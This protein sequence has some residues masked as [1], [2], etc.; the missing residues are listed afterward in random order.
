M[1]RCSSRKLRSL[2]T[3]PISV[4]AARHSG[5]GVILL[6]WKCLARLCASSPRASG[7]PVAATATIKSPQSHRIV[8]LL[9]DPA[10]RP[11]LAPGRHALLQIRCRNSRNSRP[12]ISRHDRGE[13]FQRPSHCEA[14]QEF[15]CISAVRDSSRAP[16]LPRFSSP[17]RKPMIAI[18]GCR[19]PECLARIYWLIILG[20]VLIPRHRPD[21]LREAWKV[22]FGKASVMLSGALCLSEFFTA[23]LSGEFRVTSR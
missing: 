19:H 11:R 17:S 22:P 2:K 14:G 10:S 1:P 9:G 12:V 16:A 6:F 15:C 5:N 13:R 4:S 23:R 21:K 18:E 20:K 3:K 7:N 8:A